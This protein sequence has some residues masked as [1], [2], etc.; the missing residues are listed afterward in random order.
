MTTYTAP[1][2]DMQFL[3]KE[4]AGIDAIAGLPG[5]EDATADVADAILEEAGKIASDVLAPLNT[6]GDQTGAKIVNKQVTVPPGFKE[7]FKQFSEAGWVGI[8]CDTHFGGQGMPKLIN[9]A[10]SEMWRSSNISFA[11]C[12]MLT[13]GAVEALEMAGSDELKNTY[14]PKMIGGEWTG[15]MNLTEPQAGTD[16][17][18][19]RSRAVPQADGTYRIF[20]QKI[21]ITYGDHDMTDNIVHLVLARLP[22]APE[23]VKGISLFIVPK[24]LVNADGSLGE[25]NDAWCVSIE[26][27]LGIHASPTCVMAF[28]DNGGAVGHLVGKPN[29]GLKYMFV[30]MNAA[31]FFVGVE[32][33][34]LSEVAYQKAV[35][36]ARDR[37]QGRAIEGSKEN[38]AIIKHPDVRRML[39]EMRSRTEAMRAIAYWSAAADDTGRRHPDAEQR[40]YWTGIAEFMTPIVKAWLTETGNEMTYLGVQVHGGMGFIEETGA[41]QF[42]RDARITTIYEGTTGIQALDLIGRKTSRDGGAM[43]KEVLGMMQE[44]VDALGSQGSADFARMKQAL[45]DGIAHARKAGEF[46]ANGMGNT[47]RDV[48]AGAVPFLRVMGVLC[49]GWLLSKSA[50]IAQAKIAAGDTDP[51]YPAKIITARYFADH[52]M[53]S[54]AGF[55]AEV[56]EGA[57]ST[58]ALDDAMF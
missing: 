28:G 25:R 49:G 6:S 35:A 27:K 12:P 29:E 30:M 43:L 15:T 5:F 20:G 26:H 40:K 37:V 48:A 31:R 55:A 2:K 1:L 33:L 8:S 32:G 45:T 46:V 56:L 21:F 50:L 14:L 4:I 11:L 52:A 42:M 19:V 22:D 23:G 13:M 47:P 41:A 24:F 57:Q 58:L 36:Y 3:M 18:A 54:I 51:F 38:V 10:V 16:L 44:T 34:G 17:A 7:A 9:A 39:M 53:T